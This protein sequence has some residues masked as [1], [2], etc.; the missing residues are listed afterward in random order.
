MVTVQQS[1]VSFFSYWLIMETLHNWPDFRS[2]ISK[3]WDKHFINTVAC[4]NRCKFQGNYFGGAVLTNI[5]TFYEV[6]SLG[7]T[8]WS[9][10]VGPGFEIF[11]ICAEKMYDKVCQKYGRFFLSGKNGGFSPPPQQGKDSL[12]SNF[13]HGAK[14]ETIQGRQTCPGRQKWPGKQTLFG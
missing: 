2:P 5:Q 4:S 11:T 6:R 14:V 1:R 13:S 8:W 3:F 10:L 9:D 7:M 12:P